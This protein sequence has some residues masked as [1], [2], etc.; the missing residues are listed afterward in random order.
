MTTELCDLHHLPAGQ[1]KKS[2][3]K[4]LFSFS[5]ASS[6]KRRWKTI[7]PQSLSR[8]VFVPEGVG[9]NVRDNGE[10]YKGEAAPHLCLKCALFRHFVRTARGSSTLLALRKSAMV[11]K[12]WPQERAAKM[13]AKMKRRLTRALLNA[14]SRGLQEIRG[15][16]TQGKQALLRYFQHPPL[17]ISNTP[18]FRS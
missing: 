10:W 7:H 15:T 17:S 4:L 11:C 16:I 9:D 12:K 5:R 1:E 18:T 13:C 3:T 2:K 14:L 6:L 8:C